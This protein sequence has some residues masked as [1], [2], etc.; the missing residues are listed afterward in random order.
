MN[1]AGDHG[2]DLPI[3]L[4]GEGPLRLEDVSRVARHHAR[5]ALSARADVRERIEA[6]HRVVADTVAEGLPAYGITTSL[7]G[8]SDRS[9]DAVSASAMQ[10]NVLWAHKTGAGQRL[11][12]DDVRAAMLLRLNALARGASGVRVELLERIVAVLNARITPVVHEFGSIGASGDLVPLA[13]IAGASIGHS[14]GY[15]ATMGGETIDAT[16][17]LAQAGLSPIALAPKEGLALINGT[18]ASAAVGA[19]CVMEAQRLFE[20]T[21]GFHALAVQALHASS[22][23]FHPFIHDLKPHPGQQCVAAAMRRLLHGSTMVREEHESQRS[24]HGSGLIQDR[25]SIRCIPQFMGPIVETLQQVHNQIVIEANAATDNPLIDAAGGGVYHGGNFLGQYVGTGMDRVRFDLAMMG[26][27]VDIQLSL[28]HAPEF[29]NGL[30]A[31]LVG[32]TGRA[33]NLGLKGLQLTG[34]SLASLLAFYGNPSVNHFPPYAEQFNQN[35][36]SQSFNAALLTS[37]ALRQ[38]TVLLAAALLTAAQ[39]VD[40][41]MHVLQGHYNARQSLSPESLALYDAVRRV[42]KHPSS[43]ERPCIYND[44]EQQLDMLLSALVADIEGEGA[45]A[46]AVRGVID[47]N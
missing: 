33:V 44:D 45:I 31:S 42:I 19:R 17:A 5:V 21:V 11:R 16:A 15:L 25:Y 23:P 22:Q 46:R 8:M 20:I 47:W 14:A 36:N 13:Y 1:S 38:Y 6:A 29:S 40:L 18:S 10:H 7:G 26:K 34:N 41:R 30:P 43:I 39:A 3:V 24:V 27:H 2:L 28:M 4:V 35:L 12:D 9:V 32:N 37:E